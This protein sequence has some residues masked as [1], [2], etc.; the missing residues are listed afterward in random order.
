MPFTPKDWRDW[1]DTSTP[2]TAA[3]LEDL[4]ARL[5]G[6][7]ETQPG[8]E[9]PAGATGPQ[10]PQGDTGATGPKGDTGS[11][12]PAGAKG[13]KGDTGD[14][15]SQGPKGDTGDTGPAGAKGDTG[16]TGP[17]GPTGATGV[18][19]DTGDTGPQGPTGPTG[20]A[21]ATGATG[22]AGPAGAIVGI[23]AQTAS[24]SLALAD[25]GKMVTVESAGDT[26]VTVPNNS[27]VAFDTATQVHVAR[28]GTGALKVGKS[29][30]VTLRAPGGK[31][32]LASRYSRALLAKIATNEWLISGD[33]TTASSTPYADLLATTAGAN[34][35]IY[36]RMG[37][38]GTFDV[39]GN[40]RNGTAAGGV[41][42]G[43]AS[44]LL[45]NETDGAT[46]FDGT[47][48]KATASSWDIGQNYSVIAFVKTTHSGSI[49]QIVNR[50]IGA[51]N[52]QLRI[53]SAGKAEFITINASN[54]AST[55][56]GATAINTNAVFMLVGV[57][58]WNGTTRTTRLYVNGVSD[59]TA[60]TLN[61]APLGTTS[62][63]SVGSGASSEFFPG[64]I[65]EVAI[66][67]RVLTPSEIGDLYVEA[68]F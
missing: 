42:I 67:H 30:G 31:T 58:E 48:D 22:A 65:D 66:V 55:V 40:S 37:A 1:P 51:R 26:V 34:L 59:A 23:N 24:Y 28:L 29:S 3:A 53:T 8:P 44:S 4:E 10:G 50:D 13:D 7:A 56:T 64:T 20:P 46:T 38:S 11:Q 25:A 12:G 62:T 19:G 27:S 33:L 54:Q 45:P 21:G 5:A 6:Y 39:S 47:D 60:A 18:K 36:W 16:S 68:G 32:G 15:G 61:A 2:I 17:Q 9:G 41:T 52:F 49:R 35:G 57:C 63:L 43:G 14:Q